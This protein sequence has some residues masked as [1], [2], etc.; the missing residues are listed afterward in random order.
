MRLVP[1]EPHRARL[2]SLS[3]LARDGLSLALLAPGSV[4]WRAAVSCRGRPTRSLYGA[5]PYPAEVTAGASACCVAGPIEL[6]LKH[7]A[8][9]A[10]YRFALPN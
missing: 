9:I 5:E 10:L 2:S 1:R 3:T 7:L 8:A 4:V 6:A